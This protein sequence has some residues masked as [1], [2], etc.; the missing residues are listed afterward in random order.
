M[1]SVDLAG[2][3]MVFAVL[4]ALAVLVKYER[5]L[6]WWLA[7]SSRRRRRKAAGLGKTALL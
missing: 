5:R 2:F 7:K 3:G 1:V 6:S 4:A